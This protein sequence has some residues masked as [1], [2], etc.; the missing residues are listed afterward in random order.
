[1]FRMNLIFQ[2]NVNEHISSVI[3]DKIDEIDDT[4]GMLLVACDALE[5]L[6]KLKF[7]V[8]GFGQLSWPVDIRT[9][10]AAI[11]EQVP[12]A[13]MELH[14]DSGEF[15]LDFFG[16]GIE[17]E[18]NFSWEQNLVAMKCSSR[19]SWIPQP[20]IELASLSEIRKIFNNLLRD[21]CTVIQTF[22]P[23]L[24]NIN[25]YEEFCS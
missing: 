14:R 25:Y 21:F 24:L 16:Q 1:M 7:Q 8:S 15:V 10:L 12:F 11:L 19:T 22:L 3:S 2:E 9:D 23:N 13:L 4:V 5:T 17:R 18:I 6:G 20:E